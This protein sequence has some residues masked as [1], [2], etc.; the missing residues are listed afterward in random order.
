MQQLMQLGPDDARAKLLQGFVDAVD[1]KGFVA[2]TIADI[3]RHARLSKR[4]FYEHFGDK[5]DCFL[6]VYVFATDAILRAVEQALEVN[7]DAE[8]W[9]IP[10]DEAIDAYVTA[11]E[12]NPALTRA[13]LVEIHAA[14]SRALARRREV[15]GKFAEMVREFVSIGSKKHKDI[16]PITAHMA[17]ALVGGINEL[18]VV[19]LERGPQQKLPALRQTAS[20]LLR[21]VLTAK[22]RGRR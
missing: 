11:L 16:H 13:C 22:P 19:Q 1:E 15:H 18:L 21:A 9:R 17:T 7:A 5:E 3:V 14:G 2:V 12:A 10:L 6:G 8:D 4:T 20:D